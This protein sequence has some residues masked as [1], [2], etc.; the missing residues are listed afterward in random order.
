MDVAKHQPRM[1]EADGSAVR[2]A[3]EEMPARRVSAFR[4]R[5]WVG[6]LAALIL[7]VGAVVAGLGVSARLAGSIVVE[8][9]GLLDTNRS[10]DAQALF[11]MNRA[12]GYDGFIHNFKDFVLSREPSQLTAAER[13]LTAA[14]SIAEDFLDRVSARAG[15]GSDPLPDTVSAGHI[16]EILA[17]LSR[18]RES[19]R[20][21]GVMVRERRTASEIDAAIRVDDKP[22]FE[23][24]DHLARQIYESAGDG[25]PAPNRQILI[26]KIV[27]ALGY[28]GMIH[29]FKN[30][31]LRR[32]AA[33]AA[34]A[35]RSI[36]EFRSVREEYRKLDLSVREQ[37]ALAALDH[38]VT[39][40][41]VALTTA[42]RLVAEGRGTEEIGLLVAIDDEPAVA[43]LVDLESELENSVNDAVKSIEAAFVDILERLTYATW[44][45]PVLAL[46][47][48]AATY[49]VVKTRIVVPLLAVKNIM[50]RL[51]VDDFDFD[52]S[53]A[54]RDNEFGEMSR[55]LIDLREHG[56]RRVAAEHALREHEERFRMIVDTA[57]Y[58]IVTIG[59]TGTIQ[60][61]NNGAEEIF[62]YAAAEVMGK[63]VN[64]L[65]PEPFHSEHDGYLRNYLETGT[66]KII[67]IGREVEGRRKSG[68]SFPMKLTVAGSKLSSGQVFAGMVVDLSEQKAV[69]H[70]LREQEERFRMIVDTAAYG[71]VTIG[72]TGTI[73]SFNNGAEEIFGYAA[74]EVMGKNVNI[75]MPEP[76]HSE[77]DGYLR[78]YLETGTAKIIG[79]GRD[80]E[81]RRKS[82]DSFPMKLTVAGAKLSSGQVFAGMVV[83]LS[84]QKATEDALRRANEELESFAYSVSHDLRAPLRAMSGFSEALVEDFGA[85]LGDDAREYLGRIR[86]AAHKMGRLIDD[87]LKLSRVSRVQLDFEDVDLSAIAAEIIA[88]LRAG[89]PE[90]D[91]SVFIARQVC[92]KGDRQQ[93]RI[94]LENLLGNAWKFTSK[95]PNAQLAF[96][97]V[98][99]EDGMKAYFV[100]DNGAGFDMKYADK[101]F[102][103]FE[104]LHSSAEYAGT[105]IGLATVS[106]VIAKHGGKVWTE[107]E[108]EKGTTVYFTL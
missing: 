80:V 88:D 94:A 11:R 95:V 34:A 30:F 62:G 70:A 52:V 66:A 25:G 67:G 83:D 63:N 15:D 27:R 12:L 69:E 78:N 4:I 90:R 44:L 7:A 26:A 8:N 32:D 21:A 50:G 14:D 82:G 9:I 104:R 49:W 43:G 5:T 81:G 23:A 108:I 79:I 84:E 17:V 74:D 31:V 68:D 2:P 28:G 16:E 97:I 38:I 48:I 46:A 103:P 54:D 41:T 93:L 57:A 13:K 86:A 106:R 29:H 72:E 92:V 71:I 59:E 18:Y 53:G 47:L 24:L 22:A 56:L 87:I 36:S 10:S 91:V 20:L 85:Q 60:S 6:I 39:S 98:T 61:F 3:A 76:F 51:A 107:S 1:S 33:H 64:I 65:M 40:Y 35:R 58:G 100:R 77:H 96:N 102:R 45:A 73:R 42:E 75:L 19:V 89:E 99:M 101:L 105:G 37:N 55:A